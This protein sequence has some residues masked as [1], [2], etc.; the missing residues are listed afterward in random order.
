MSFSI[1]ATLNKN[2]V[3]NRH[4]PDNPARYKKISHPHHITSVAGSWNTGNLWCL[5]SH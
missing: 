4:T 3:D 5:H 1:Q 2:T